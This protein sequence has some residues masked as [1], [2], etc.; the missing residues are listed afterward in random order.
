MKTL[1]LL[2]GSSYL[3]RAF[4]A[5]PDLRTSSGEP[6]GAIRGFIG[7][8]RTLRQQVQADYLAQF[9][10]LETGDLTIAMELWQTTAADVDRSVRAV[11]AAVEAARA[12][13]R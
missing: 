8:L 1:L 7:M 11:E 12:R 4:H 9:A 2:D 13:V 10:G 3:Y 6:T 5:L